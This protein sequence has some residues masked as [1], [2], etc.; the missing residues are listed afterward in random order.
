M[1][2]KS[3]FLPLI[4]SILNY[5]DKHRTTQKCFV[6]FVTLGK[7]SKLPWCKM[8]LVYVASIFKNFFYGNELLYFSLQNKRKWIFM[9]KCRYLS[10]FLSG[11]KF[12]I[13]K[14]WQQKSLTDIY[15]IMVF[16]DL[17][18]SMF[19]QGHNYAKKS[20]RNMRSCKTNK[21]IFW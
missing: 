17:W 9:K 2:K 18:K 1:N 20:A 10:P 14:L 6:C 3:F 8:L 7:K 21:S 16:K 13:F 15:N 19:H 4:I 11:C 12:D 5:T